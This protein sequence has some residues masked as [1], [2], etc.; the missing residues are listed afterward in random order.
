MI[1]WNVGLKIGAGFALSLA[2]LVVVGSVSHRSTVNLVETSDW[3]EHTHE[4]L[5]TITELLSDLKDAETGERGFVITGDESFLEPY[6]AALKTTDLNLKALRE[7]TQDNPKQQRNIDRLEPL[8]AAKYKVVF[9]IIAARRDQTNGFEA[10]HQLLIKE[11][12]KETMDAIRGLIREMQEEEYALLEVRTSEATVTSDNAKRT[13]VWGIVM[14]MVVLTIVGTAITRN[15]AKPLRAVTETAKRIS[16][17]DLTSIIVADSRQDEVGQLMRAFAAMTDN[18]RQL[19]GE[20]TEGV[21]V[22]GAAASE[23]SASTSQLASSASQ[24]A[25]AVSE[26][27][28]TV[29]EVRQ[30]TEVAS[31][32]AQA[33]A[34]TAQHS[35][36]I[37]QD[38]R[39]STEEAS[40]GMNLIRLQMEAIAATMTTLSERSQAVGQIMVTVEDLATQS[41]LLAVNAAIEAAKA[42][43]H[44]KGFGVVAQEVK[45]LAEQ[46]RQATTQVRTILGDVQKATATAVMAIEQGGK[47]VEAGSNQVKVADGSIKTLADSMTQAVQAAKQIAAS[48]QQQLVGVSQVAAAM[49]NIKLATSQNVVSSKQLEA[50]AH[51]LSELGQRLRT[52]VARYKLNPSG[53]E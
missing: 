20:M 8:V 34:D 52:L 9:D 29:E 32:R 12:G 24:S 16:Q 46:S 50:A 13:I 10:A 23:I 7:L 5:G 22:L 3:V 30:T 37:S 25:A 39:H 45:L 14:A 15:I 33:V 40:R 41:N 53:Q 19:T 21:N 44:G 18:L 11:Q 6:H 26:T 49:E 42:G 27:T 28:T 35:E 38:G 17:G 4:V 47:A 36:Q 48:N 31:Q 43:E 1:K 51:N 2:I